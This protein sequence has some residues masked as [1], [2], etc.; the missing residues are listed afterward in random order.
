[1]LGAEVMAEID[2]ADLRDLADRACIQEHA[3]GCSMLGEMRAAGMGG[4]QDSEG[5]M[6]AFLQ[7]CELGYLAACDRLEEASQ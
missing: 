3:D 1:M 4:E 6:I 2:Q 5:S 7:A